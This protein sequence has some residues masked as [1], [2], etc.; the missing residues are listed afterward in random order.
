MFTAIGIQTINMPNQSLFFNLGNLQD[1]ESLRL[2]LSS[3]KP[4]LFNNTWFI[5]FTCNWLRAKKDE[6]TVS[7]SRSDIQKI[8]RC[9]KYCYLS[10]ITGD[11]IIQL[12]SVILPVKLLQ[13]K[14]ICNNFIAVKRW[15]CVND[16]IYVCIQGLTSR[17][18]HSRG[19]LSKQAFSMHSLNAIWSAFITTLST[20]NWL[21]IWKYIQLH[22][23]KRFVV[24]NSWMMNLGNSHLHKYRDIWFI[25]YD[26]YLWVINSMR[27]KI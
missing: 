6:S 11:M 2:R 10:F 24:I 26:E 15:A 1:P 9:K 23:G 20:V 22:S 19:A 12:I 13:N 3:P 8:S 17:M 5:S 25:Q 18:N 14:Y 7:K 4:V 16:S 21:W 27:L